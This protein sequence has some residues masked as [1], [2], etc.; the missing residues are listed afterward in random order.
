MSPETQLKAR[1]WI[2]TLLMMIL[3]MMMM[4]VMMM[5]MTHDV[6]VVTRFSLIARLPA[7][8]KGPLPKARHWIYTLRLRLYW[9]TATIGLFSQLIDS[10]NTPEDL[11]L[12][13]LQIGNM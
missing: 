6:H 3:M 4:M 12:L 5:M 1:A 13:G 10:K 8:P 7:S 11:I 9:L 2:Y